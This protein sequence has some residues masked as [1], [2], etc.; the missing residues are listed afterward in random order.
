MRNES[1]DDQVHSDLGQ[2]AEAFAY[3]SSFFGS[4]TSFPSNSRGSSIRAV[5]IFIILIHRSWTALENTNLGNPVSLKRVTVSDIEADLKRLKPKRSVGNDG[6]PPYTCK[7]YGELI[8]Q[9]LT[10]ISNIILDTFLYPYDWAVSKA[11]PIPK[12]EHLEEVWNY[13]PILPIRL[14]FLNQPYLLNCIK[15]PKLRLAATAWPCT[16]K[17][18]ANMSVNKLIHDLCEAFDEKTP[19]QVDVIYT[20]FR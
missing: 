19:L 7:A 17:V 16:E 10:H 15:K 20:D 2:I 3:F 18:N 9:P 8:T 13:R 5:Q 14:K 4:R 1:F 11:V 6:V 12:N